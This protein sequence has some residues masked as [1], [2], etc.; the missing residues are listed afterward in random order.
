MKFP[1][2]T[3]LL[4]LIFSFFIIHYSLFI[5]P[6]SAQTTNLNTTSN[7]NPTVPSNLHTWTQNVMIEVMAAATC[8]LAGVDPV[9]PNQKCLGVDQKTGSI[10]FVEEGGGAIGVM[11]NF[12]AMTFTPPLH[13]SDYFSYLAQNFGIAKPAF[14]QVT[15]FSSLK[16]LM[17]LWVAFRNIVYLLFVLV[18]VIVGVAIMLRVKIDPRTV[19]TIENQI[20]KIIVGLVLVTFS[21]AIAGFLIDLMYVSTYLVSNVVADANPSAIPP[22]MREK[23]LRSTHPIDAVNIMGG[24]GGKFGGLAD[25]AG[26]PAEAIG[27]FISPIFDNPGGR[28][29]VGIV[30]GIL[31]KLAAKPV[32]DTLDTIL[33]KIGA[34]V[35]TVIQPGIGTIVGGVTGGAIGSLITILLGGAVGGLFAPQIMGGITSFIAFLVIVIALLWALFRLWFELIK[36]YIFILLDV[37]LAPFFVVIGLFPGSPIGF[38]AWMRDILANLSAFPVTIAMFL[39]GRVFMS[40]FGKN[41]PNQFAPPLIGNPADTSAFGALIGLGIILMTPQVVEMMKAVFKAPKMDMASIARAVG[42]GVGFPFGV[43]KGIISTRMGSEEY[44]VVKGGPG[45]QVEY[46]QVGLGRALLGRIL[47]R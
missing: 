26:R 13:T 30:T 39:L 43:G 46:G 42:T 38:G 34:V 19:M 18:F 25:I 36:A 31:T 22:E 15:G 27:G 35:G 29:A 24:T 23:L 11:S 14:A 9:N 28:L 17:G 16:P 45:Q 47:G 21:F 8:Q 44:R 40:A 5:S 3:K 10:G 7:A 33:T 41:E 4:V 32:A 1:A 12:I 20:P 37:V 2:L 6:V